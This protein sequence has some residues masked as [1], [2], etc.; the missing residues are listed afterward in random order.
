MSEYTVTPDAIRSVAGQVASGAS[1]IDAQRSALLARIQGLGDSWQGQAASAL[2]ALYEKWDADI[3]SLHTT[4]TEIGQ[5]MQGAA[6]AYEA[7]ETGVR[8]SFSS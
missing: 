7:T 8:Q 3:R 4:L 5:T 2:Q 6:T 1:E